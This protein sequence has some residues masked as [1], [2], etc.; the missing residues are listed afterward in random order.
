MAKIPIGVEL[1]RRGVVND[2]QIRQAI[3]Y[4]KLNP[5][6]R[7]GDIIYSL[8]LADAK[9]LSSVI[10]ELFGYPSV[11]LDSGSIAINPR[12]FY[13]LDIAKETKSLPFAVEGDKC[14]VAFAD[15]DRKSVV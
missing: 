14:K 1:V 13:S 8:G 2:S 9:Q 10:S 6:M 15:L 7:L 11:L 5:H 3:E 12:S 4:Q